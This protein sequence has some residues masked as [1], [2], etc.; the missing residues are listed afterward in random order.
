MNYQKLDA[1]LAMA[2]NEVQDPEERNLTVFIHTKLDADTAAV[3]AFLENL[4]IIG[5]TGGKNIYTAT[6]S[7][8]AISLLSE[9][10]WVHHLKLSQKF[11]LLNK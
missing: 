9:Q 4:G 3:T 8:N 11:R 10:S 1:A 6:L 7:Q 5:V 2:L